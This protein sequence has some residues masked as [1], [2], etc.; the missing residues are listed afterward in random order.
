[1]PSRVRA[2]PLLLL[3]GLF[4]DPK[5]GPTSSS[6]TIECVCKADLSVLNCLLFLFLTHDCPSLSPGPCWSFCCS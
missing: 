1:M 3:W 5:G 4:V 6:R 2:I